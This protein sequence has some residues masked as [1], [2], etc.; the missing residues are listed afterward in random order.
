MG[1]LY[2]PTNSSFGSS[3]L[4]PSVAAIFSLVSW[5]IYLQFINKQFGLLTSFYLISRVNISTEFERSMSDSLE[6]APIQSKA[7]TRGKSRDGTKPTR[8]RNT[9][10][11][12]GKL[13]QVSE[14]ESYAAPGQSI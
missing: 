1:S 10:A 2:I 13:T 5:L 3:F 6:Q 4:F 14:G 9:V 12:A 11:A 8:G 7:T